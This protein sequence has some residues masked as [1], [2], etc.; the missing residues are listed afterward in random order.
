MDDLSRAIRQYVDGL[1][2]PVA[3]EEATARDRRPVRRWGPLAALAGA[4][5]VLVSFAVIVGVRLATDPGQVAGPATTATV[6][7]S[8]PATTTLPAVPPPVPTTA[9]GRTAVPDLVGL[10]PGQ[11]AEVAAAAGLDLTV[12]QSVTEP[13]SVGFVFGQDPEP[14]EEVELGTAVEVVVG[15]PPRCD[16]EQNPASP[17]EDLQEVTVLFG[18]GDFGIAPNV[19]YPR[20]R[21]VP[22]ALGEFEAVLTGL[23][24]GLTPDEEEAGFG[25]FFGPATAASLESVEFRGG[26]VVVDFN[27][28]IIVNG[29]STSTGGLYF[30]AEILA[31]LFQFSQVNS[32]ELRFNGSCEAWSTLFEGDSCQITTRRQWEERV[33]TW[34]EWRAEGAV[35]PG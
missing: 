7:T 35:G 6:S 12:G 15:I 18:C 31:N 8:L 32:V 26:H 13:S 11:A 29:M 20:V 3:L 1:A 17:R 30:N 24:G 23:L 28:A 14:G 16:L 10:D 25:T 2:A 5:L 27:D 4:G 22:A 21:Q 34:A 33:A 9:P 19:V